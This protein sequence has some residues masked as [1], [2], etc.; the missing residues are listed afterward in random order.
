M[1]VR[2]PSSSIHPAFVSPAIV[3]VLERVRFSALRRLVS[4]H[5]IPQGP[6]LG[7]QRSADFVWRVS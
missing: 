3:S 7:A 4:I 1:H 5:K 6:P 2:T